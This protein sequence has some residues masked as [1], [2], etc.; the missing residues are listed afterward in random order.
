M[1][2]LIT[3][4]MAIISFSALAQSQTEIQTFKVTSTDGVT[5]AYNVHGVGS[6][7]L[8][9]VHGWSCDRSYWKEQIQPFSARYRVVSIDLGGHGESGFGRKNWTIYS[10]GSDV[11]TVVREL[12]LKRVI[13]IGHSMGGDVIV[14]AALQ[15][16]GRVAGLIMVDTYKKLGD[17]RSMEQI[18][19]F[20]EDFGIDFETKVQ[21]LVRSLYLPTSDT[22][23]VEYVAKDMSSAPTGV[24][25]SAIKSS[26]TH[27][28]QITHDLEL[29]NLPVIA[30]NAGNEPTDMESMQLHGVETHIMSRVG[31]FPMMEDPQRF[32]ELLE[33]LIEKLLSE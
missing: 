17:G 20:V 23:L 6:T 9:F 12:D 31:H 21:Q 25:L 16:P 18:Q 5:I 22:S 8:V 24:A 1:K 27:S 3:I 19:A 26:F 13:L 14:D 15:L 32:N 11:A 29:L 33:T 4:V 10:F 28:R 2:H 7:G 30:I